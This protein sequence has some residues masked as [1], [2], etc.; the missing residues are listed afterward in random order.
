[1]KSRET[2]S[3]KMT[4]SVRPITS[5]A[6]LAI[7]A[8]R[9]GCRRCIRCRGSS[10]RPG[11]RC[12]PGRRAADPPMRPGSHARRGHGRC[13][14]LVVVSDNLI[15]RVRPRCAAREIPSFSA[16]SVRLP[17]V[18]C[19]VRS[20]WRRS[21]SFN[22]RNSQSCCAGPMRSAPRA[23]ESAGETLPCVCLAGVAWVLLTSPESASAIASFKHR[24]ASAARGSRAPEGRTASG[25]IPRPRR[26]RR[27][28]KP[29]GPHTPT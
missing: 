24:P 29:P 20:M 27:G 1:V 16:A 5:W 10:R 2:A 13:S 4:A 11:R 8:R 22:F 14:V 15:V 3:S 12:P 25:C 17:P 6:G 28:A 21:T 19:S 18:R 9:P 7:D 23:D 26:A